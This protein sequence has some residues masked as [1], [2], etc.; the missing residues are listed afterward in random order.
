MNFDN[1]CEGI[2][3][4]IF[5]QYFSLLSAASGV[6]AM[7]VSAIIASVV[8]SSF[9]AMATGGANNATTAKVLSI[10]SGSV[11]LSVATLALGIVSSVFMIIGLVKA[12]SDELNFQTAL[13]FTF[14]SL[15]CTLGANVFSKVPVLPI[16]IRIGGSVCALLSIMYVFKAIMN[17][18]EMIGEMGMVDDGKVSL[19]IY[20]ILKGIGILSSL[21]PNV[22]PIAAVSTLFNI[23]GIAATVLS[24]LVVLRYL[25]KAKKTLSLSF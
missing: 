4:M 22:F 9:M 15:G 24:T 23:I 19:K 25:L 12:K 13:M 16:L 3:K 6:L 7:I 11:L 18:S 8:S 5:A 10:G 14:I 17:L 2:K 1:A 20:L 21:L